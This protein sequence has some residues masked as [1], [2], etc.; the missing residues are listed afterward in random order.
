MSLTTVLTTLGPVISNGLKLAYEILKRSTPK[1]AKEL[2]ELCLK[3][4]DIETEIRSIHQLLPH[5]RNCGRL[6]ELY[7]ETIE[8][9][10]K[11][12]LYQD[13]ATNEFYRISKL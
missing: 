8:I 4:I 5:E 11:I 13:L 10:K 2:E 9:D 6:E 3:K 12:S 7:N 1:K